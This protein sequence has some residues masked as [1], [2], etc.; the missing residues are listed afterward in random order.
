MVQVGG[1]RGVGHLAGLA[2]VHGQ[3]GVGGLHEEERRLA[4]GEAHFLGVLGIVAAHAQDA[5]DRENRRLALHGHGG[6]S[7]RRQDIG[8]HGAALTPGKG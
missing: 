8:C 4:A 6:G 2:R 3:H 1:E 7:M 5:P